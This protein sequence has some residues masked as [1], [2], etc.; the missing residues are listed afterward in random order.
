MKFFVFLVLDQYFGIPM[1]FSYTHVGH[2]LN[3][4][5]YFLLGHVLMGAGILYLGKTVPTIYP[6]KNVSGKCLYSCDVNRSRN[7]AG[8]STSSAPSL[9]SISGTMIYLRIP[10]LPW[11]AFLYVALYVGAWKV[12]P[13]IYR[14]LSP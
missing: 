6:L 8:K 7:I 1:Y 4:E 13:V 9:S 11:H 10:E 5:K 14:G 12:I 2:S 3:V